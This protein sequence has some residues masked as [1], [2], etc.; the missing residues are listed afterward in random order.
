MDDAV[1]HWRDRSEHPFLWQCI[2]AALKDDEARLEMEMIRK[3][4][5][6]V[7]AERYTREATLAANKRTLVDQLRLR[8]KRIPPE[9]EQTIQTTQ[10]ADQLAEWLRRFATADDLD[11]VGIVPEE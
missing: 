10:D 8:F 2:D 5:A 1:Y 4:M 6:Q 7:E 9:I 3:T 11:A